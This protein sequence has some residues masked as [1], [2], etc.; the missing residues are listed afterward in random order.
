MAIIKKTKKVS[1]RLWEKKKDT[2]FLGMLVGTV[3]METSV[4]F[5]QKVL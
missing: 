5:P 3:I 1:V 2:V 4:E